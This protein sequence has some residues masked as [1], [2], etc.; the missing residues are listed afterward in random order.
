MKGSW[1][2]KLIERVHNVNAASK[3]RSLSDES[4]QPSAKRGRPKQKSPILTR[5]PP[6]KDTADDSI[7]V[8]RNLEA[9]HKEIEK[10]NPNKEKVLSLCRQTFC[11][12]REDIL[13]EFEDTT[14]VGLLHDYKEL[15]KS[16]VVSSEI[17][18][19]C[20]F[21]Q[22]NSRTSQ[23]LTKACIEGLD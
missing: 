8:T 13:N 17:C 9:L 18:M 20:C 4:G 12:R 23:I 10:N 16:Y 22:H 6:L 11:K 14:T 15:H 7:T 1:E 3:K 19:R 21:S 5:Y 2:K